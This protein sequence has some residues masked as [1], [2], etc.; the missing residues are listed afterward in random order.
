MNTVWLATWSGSVTESGLCTG[1]KPQ[2]QNVLRQKVWFPLGQIWA[3]LR[4]LIGFVLDSGQEGPWNKVETRAVSGEWGENHNWAARRDSFVYIKG[5][6]KRDSQ[7]HCRRG[8]KEFTKA[9]TTAWRVLAGLTL[10]VTISYDFSCPL[11]LC[12][13]FA[14]G[15]RMIKQIG[16]RRQK[17]R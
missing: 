16:E 8:S 11:P 12:P 13:S 14:G 3:T 1:D 15:V 4:W 17:G 6:A 10:T 9:L 5:T 2:S 7:Q